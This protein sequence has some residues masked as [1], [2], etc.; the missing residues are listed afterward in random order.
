MLTS[1][2][3]RDQGT[4]HTENLKQAPFGS[5]QGRSF[6]VEERKHVPNSPFNHIVRVENTAYFYTVGFGSDVKKKKKS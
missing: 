6:C 3:N 2:L 1:W 5:S 4:C